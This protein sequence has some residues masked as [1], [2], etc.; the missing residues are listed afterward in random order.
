MTHDQYLLVKTESP[1]ALDATLLQMS[2]YLARDN[3][4]A[5]ITE[6]GAYVVL[7]IGSIGY[8][9]FAIENQGYGEVIGIFEGKIR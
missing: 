8:I 5:F 7:S 4:N 2:A 9:K 3:Q 1:E 6:N